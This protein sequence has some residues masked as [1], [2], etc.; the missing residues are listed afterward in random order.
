MSY[1][2]VMALSLSKYMSVLC[3]F[4]WTFVLGMGIAVAQSDSS[5]QIDLP[6][7]QAAVS[8]SG[9]VS[10]LSFR[11]DQL[12]C[13][14][15]AESKVDWVSVS[16]VPPGSNIPPVLQYAV[17]P[18]LSFHSRTT[19]ISVGGQEMTIA[20]EAGPQPGIAG[21]SSL[22]WVVQ[23]KSAKPEKKILHVGSDDPSLE[24]TAAP[25]AETIR[26]LSVQQGGGD[27]R[28]FEVSINVHDLKAGTYAGRIV[29]HAPGARNDPLSIPV[30]LKILP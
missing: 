15:N 9:A 8:Y 20:Q 3:R 17:Q 19:S 26:W 16:V 30:N 29:V 28:S 25:S 4:V 14:P 11:A 18:N 6:S 2:V 21:P 5:C 27:G 12:T 23:E 13:V 24:V 22:D 7:S 10:Q 1:H